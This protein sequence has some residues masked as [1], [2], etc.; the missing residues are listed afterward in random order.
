MLFKITY[1]Q[2]SNVTEFI[3]NAFTVPQKKANNKRVLVTGSAL[4]QY[5]A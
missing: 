2:S 1:Q 4:S 3:S 5:F